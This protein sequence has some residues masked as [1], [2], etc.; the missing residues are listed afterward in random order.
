MLAL[1]FHV[2][3]WD[4]LGWTDRFAQ[5]AFTERQRALM[6]PSGARYVYTPQVVVNGRDA[7]RWTLPKAN[8]ASALDLQL[9]RDGGTVSARISPRPG[10]AVASRQL[11]G[12]WALLEDGHRSDVKAGE[13]AGEKLRHDHVVR[14]YQPVAAWAADR[15]Q[16][17]QW[18]LP[19]VQESE[20]GLQR[21]VAFVVVNPETQKPVQALALGC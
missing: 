6:A 9:S 17:L 2:T 13:N 8:D 19:R 20:A 5:A 1:S 14:Q 10:G 4:R 3:Y 7:P 18:Q 15:E 12:Y 11:A 21:R 16:R